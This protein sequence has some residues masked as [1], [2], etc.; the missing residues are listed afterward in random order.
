MSR[1]NL[2]GHLTR[3]NFGERCTIK[4]CSCYE[5]LCGCA[6]TGIS[7]YEL[8]YFFKNESEIMYQFKK[9]VLYFDKQ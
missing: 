8:L 3:L 7:R 9:M 6:Q 1:L 5:V 4:S 2:I